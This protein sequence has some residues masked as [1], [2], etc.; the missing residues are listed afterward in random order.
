MHQR[1]LWVLTNQAVPVDSNNLTQAKLLGHLRKKSPLF[2]HF[3]TFENLNPVILNLFE[4]QVPPPK[5][6]VS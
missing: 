5:K 3:S 1:Y 2:R 4:K 6:K